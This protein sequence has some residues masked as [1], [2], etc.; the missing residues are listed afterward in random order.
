[1]QTT[2]ILNDVGNE[3]VHI[4]CT[5]V[6]SEDSAEMLVMQNNFPLLQQ[7]SAFQS[8]DFG[9]EGKFGILDIV[10]LF[11]ILISMMAFN[12]VNQIVGIVVSLSFVFAMAWFSIIEIPTAFLGIIAVI[13]MFAIGSH[14]KQ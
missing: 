1:M 7:I 3:I 14:R 4:I 2:F 9:T 12:R 10:V 13:L 5:D 11:T 8:G 6:I